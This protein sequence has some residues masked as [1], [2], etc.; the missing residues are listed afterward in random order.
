MSTPTNS[1]SVPVVPGP[2]RLAT[3]ADTDWTVAA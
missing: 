3:G 1:V 2:G